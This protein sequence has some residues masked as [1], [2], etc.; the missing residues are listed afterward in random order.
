MRV[1]LWSELY[2]PH[3]GGPEILAAR[4]LPALRARG[5]ECLVV[6]SHDSLALPDEA[7]HEGIA[8]R[9][10][11]FRAVTARRDLAGVRGLRA[12]VA[13]LK[14]DFAPD[15]VHVNGLGPSLLLNCCEDTRGAFG[16]GSIHRSSLEAP[17]RSPRHAAIVEDLVAGR[18]EKYALCRQCPL[19]PAGPRPA[20]RRIAIAPRRYLGERTGEVPSGSG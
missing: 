4:L 14:R 18:R 6:T 11:P 9:R 16:L 2:W 17:W 7:R 20:G 12:E 8:V 13:A 15:V 3:V 5:H 1:L 19:P 10:L